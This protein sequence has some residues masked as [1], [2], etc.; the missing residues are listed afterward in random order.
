MTNEQNIL[1]VLGEGRGGVTGRPLLTPP[2]EGAWRAVCA[3][4]CTP[5]GG[6]QKM[7][8]AAGHWEHPGTSTSKLVVSYQAI[9]VLV[10]PCETPD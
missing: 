10:E 5:A 1:E 3:A 4:C 2:W 8:Q 7:R 6:W 9:Q